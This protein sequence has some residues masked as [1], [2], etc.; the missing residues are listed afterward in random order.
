[1]LEFRVA[2]LVYDEK[3]DQYVTLTPPEGSNWEVAKYHPTNAAQRAVRISS[4]FKPN[5]YPGLMDLAHDTI[6]WTSLEIHAIQG[7]DMVLIAQDQVSR[8]YRIYLYNLANDTVALTHF[9]N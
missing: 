3:R 7:D 2:G 1:A 4:R 9:Q 8:K 5:L 6:E